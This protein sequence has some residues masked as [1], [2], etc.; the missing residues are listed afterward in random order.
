MPWQN[1]VL[2]LVLNLA[3]MVGYYKFDPT[4]VKNIYAVG[5]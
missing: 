3:E 5:Y 1:Q 4:M 2:D